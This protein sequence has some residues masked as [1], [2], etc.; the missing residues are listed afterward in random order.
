[1]IVRVAQFFLLFGLL[2]V[3]LF[4]S[5][6]VVAAPQYTYCLAGILLLLFASSLFRRSRPASEPSERFRLL[7]SLSRRVRNQDKEE[8]SE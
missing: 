6:D 8:Q 3:L 2:M 5:S 4:I 1:M 7:R